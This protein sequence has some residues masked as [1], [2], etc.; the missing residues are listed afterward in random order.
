MSFRFGF[1]L[2]AWPAI[3]TAQPCAPTCSDD[4]RCFE[5]RCL[6]ADEI[7]EERVRAEVVR[8]LVEREVKA[9]L[10]SRRRHDGF[11]IRFGLAGGYG[12]GSL[13]HVEG[14]ERDLDG[15][16]GGFDLRIGGTVDGFAIGFF[17]SIRGSGAAQ[18]LRAG[19]SVDWYPDPTKG[20]H[21]GLGLTIDQLRV[22]DANP[23]DLWLNG[24]KLGGP[25]GTVRLGYDL[26]VGDQHSL[27]LELDVAAFSGGDGREEAALYETGLIISY[28]YH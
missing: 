28:L 10:A 19:V 11:F 26:W 13:E 2:L 9:E 1:A 4:T 7:D 17:E 12:L 3:A 21:V 23:D 14:G 6:T 15:G 24:A 22:F 5:G 25:G 20:L 18:R 27:G 16:L 8:R